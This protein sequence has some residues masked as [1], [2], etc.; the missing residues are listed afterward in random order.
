MTVLIAVLAGAAVVAVVL[1]VLTWIYG[2]SPERFT[3]PFG[4]A[5]VEAGERTAD[6]AAEFWD[7]LRRGR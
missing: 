6:T 4:A 2:W 7:W 3:R 5:A 1:A